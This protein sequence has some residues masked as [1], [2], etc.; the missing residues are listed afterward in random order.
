[1]S[2]ASY[3][4][5]MR[6]WAWIDDSD[7]DA[8]LGR[9]AIGAGVR[10]GR[11]ALGMSQRQLAWRED[12]GIRDG[13]PSSASY[14]RESHREGDGRPAR[15]SGH[16]GRPA[17]QRFVLPRWSSRRGWS[18]GARIWASRTKGPPCR[19][20][21]ALRRPWSVGHDPGSRRCIDDRHASD[22]RDSDA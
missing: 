7:E 5:G 9:K 16:Q 8:L 3:A 10:S 15:G 12:L 22:T 20:T 21:R 13:P 19:S 4:A 17:H 14:Y 1:M 11:L 2:V 18:P 6:G